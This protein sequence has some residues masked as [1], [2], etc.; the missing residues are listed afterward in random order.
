MAS[1]P[2]I[3]PANR[4]GGRLAASVWTQGWLRLR[5]GVI[6]LAFIV[7]VIGFSFA[8]PEF[9]ST[10]NMLNIGR[11]TAIVSVIA[12]AMTF[13]L[14]AGEIDLS[15]GSVMAVSSLIASLML[16]DG[17]HWLT[18]SLAGLVM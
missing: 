12:F 11:Q 15:I 16:R 1:K 9:L 4:Q 18:A 7:L 6:Y 13:V 2:E 14:T 17:S 8:S 10:S 5:Q 3:A